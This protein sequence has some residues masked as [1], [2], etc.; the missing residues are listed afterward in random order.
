MLFL[1]VVQSN[2]THRHFAGG[3]QWPVQIDKEVT[4]TTWFDVLT[5]RAKEVSLLQCYL[6]RLE[7]NSCIP[8]NLTYSTNI[9]ES[10][11]LFKIDVDM[12]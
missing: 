1:I 8:C 4:D 5:E 7:T 11:Q 3:I 10:L 6:N 9:I 12:V 2:E